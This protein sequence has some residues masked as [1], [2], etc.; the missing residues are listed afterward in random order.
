MIQTFDTDVAL[1]GMGPTGGVLASLLGSR[2]VRVDVFE[3]DAAVFPKPRAVHLDAETMRVLQ[4]IGVTETIAPAVTPI[5]G[6]DMLNADGE[7]I[8]KYVAPRGPG[9]LGWAEGF[10]FYQPE[11]ERALRRRAA[12]HPSVSV[13]AGHE[14]RS[15]RAEADG[16]GAVLEV[17]SAG[18]TRPV[19]ARFAVGCCGARSLTRAALG[20]GLAD[21]G[22]DQP[23]LV[24]DLVLRGE[25]PLPDVTVQYCEPAR[26]ATYV[27]LPGARRRFEIMVMPGDD[28]AEMVREERIR[29]LLAR[30]L[31][32]DDYDLE[33]AAV[34]TFHGLVAE[35]WRRG[36]LLI[37]GDAAHQMPPFL[38]QGMCSGIRDAANLAWKLELV[39]RG[40]AAES[41][42]DSYQG[43]REPHVRRIIEA[44]LFLGNLIQT[45][46]PNVARQ[47]DAAAASQGPVPLTPPVYPLGPG[48][49]AAGPAAGIPFPQPPLDGGGA[50]DDLLGPGFALVGSVTPSAE[51]ARVLDAI[52]AAT[53]H[54]PHPAIAEW[55]DAQGG[56]AAV[57]RPDRM[58]L[59]V[60]SGA[61]G[62]DEALAPLAAHLTAAPA[63]ALQD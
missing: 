38:G 11:L 46:D 41:L 33:R 5:R 34:Y 35:R 13:H 2:G 44:D 3:R 52:G 47:R 60:V 37:A 32:P 58:V 21:Y 27:P 4:Q 61:S 50:H 57:V 15:V 26:P 40:A 12:E 7:L 8:Y 36:P 42:L 51:A 16:A 62:L 9:P 48:L 23:W 19:R 49:C 45:T 10:M 43:E 59:A 24:L 39:V 22:L 55:L 28:P 53:I 63:H 31:H 29:A 54:T 20:S 17:D 25:V 30:W 14:V 56:R 18:G 1:I 6:M